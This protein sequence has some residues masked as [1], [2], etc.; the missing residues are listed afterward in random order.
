MYQKPKRDA[1]SI[2]ESSIPHKNTME[3]TFYCTKKGL[4]YTL[5][6]SPEY[7]EFLSLLSANDKFLFLPKTPETLSRVVV[8]ARMMGM[9]TIVNKN[10]GAA[11]EPWFALKGDKLIEYMAQQRIDIPAKV[12][13]VLNE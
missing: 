13:E 11:Y 7:K 4:P 6:S 1:Y 2:L 12:L 3:A 9:K 5:I 10:I 8:E